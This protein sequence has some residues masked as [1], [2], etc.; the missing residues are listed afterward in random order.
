[1]ANPLKT[2]FLQPQEKAGGM[3]PLGIL[4]RVGIVFGAIAM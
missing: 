4:G 2:K 1:M 3:G